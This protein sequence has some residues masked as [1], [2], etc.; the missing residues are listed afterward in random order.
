MLGHKSE[1]RSGVSRGLVQ[2]KQGQTESEEGMVLRLPESRCGVSSS[3]PCVSRLLLHTAGVAAATGWPAATAGPAA[4]APTVARGADDAVR[5]CLVVPLEEE[6][7]C[8]VE[9]QAWIEREREEEREKYLEEGF[10]DGLR[11]DAGLAEPL[12]A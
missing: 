12:Q 5:D 3:H 9:G 6:G 2:G 10:A 4:A 8:L 7:F 1:S 11:V